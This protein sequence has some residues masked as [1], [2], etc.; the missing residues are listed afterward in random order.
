MVTQ[1]TIRI[2]HHSSFSECVTAFPCSLFLSCNSLQWFGLAKFCL[3][4]KILEQNC[5]TNIFLTQNL[6]WPNFVWLKS[7]F[8]PNSFY[9]KYYLRKNH[10]D[11]H[12]F[13]P[14]IFLCSETFFQALL[15]EQGLTVCWFS[16]CEWVCVR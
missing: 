1:L 9:P 16:A 3:S 2:I 14:K 8:E 11:K 10:F 12:I 15:V 5:L 7:S 4:K 6:F 13:G